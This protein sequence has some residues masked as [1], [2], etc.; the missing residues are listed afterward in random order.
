VSYPIEERIAKD[1]SE[2]RSNGRPPRAQP[3]E[4]TTATDETR[5]AEKAAFV[6]YLKYGKR[7][8]SILR[9]QRDLSTGNAGVV[10]AQDF[11]GMKS[12][13][14]RPKKRQNCLQCFVGLIEFN[15]GVA[16]FQ[17][18]V[19]ATLLSFSLLDSVSGKRRR[20]GAP[21]TPDP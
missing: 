4:G 9:E 11:L 7:D 15:K 2:Q 19:L 13:R 20:P 21:L 6:D 18:E 3:G 16:T 1:A 14:A 10:I 5:A 12:T 17:L 8:T